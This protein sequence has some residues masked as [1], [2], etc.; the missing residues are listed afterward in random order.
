MD[1]GYISAHDFIKLSPDLSLV[2]LSP[3]LAILRGEVRKSAVH[4]LV[5]VTILQHAEQ[6]TNLA[7]IK[8]ALGEMYSQTEVIQALAF[9]LDRSYV[10]LSVKDVSNA[11]LWAALGVSAEQVDDRMR[12]VKLCVTG[13]D[14]SILKRKLAQKGL[15]VTSARKANLHVFVTGDATS[16]YWAGVNQKKLMLQ[17]SWCLLQLS[18]T[19]MLLGPVFSKSSGCWRCFAHN[20]LHNRPVDRFL[21]SNHIDWTIIPPLISD[22]LFEL[23]SLEIAKWVVLGE[24]SELSDHLIRLSVL[25]LSVSRHRARA[26]PQCMDCGCSEHLDPARKPTC[27]DFTEPEERYTTSGGVRHH[28]PTTTVREWK[29]LV[30]PMLGIVSSCVSA[31]STLNLKFCIATTD[32]GGLDTSYQGLRRALAFRAFGKGATE[33]EAQASA[34]GEAIERYSIVFQG[35]EI[36][37]NS[38]FSAFW[39]NEAIDPSSCLLMSDAQYVSSAGNLERFRPD[40]AREWSPL[41]SL[42][43]QDW[44]WLPTEYLYF[45]YPVTRSVCPAD[46]NGLA[47]GNTIS[48]AVVQGFLELIERDAF[49][50]WWANRIHPPIYVREEIY[51]LSLDE[52]L[53]VYTSMRRKI[54]FLDLTHDAAIPVVLAL[55]WCESECG[56]QQILFAAGAH[57]DAR[58]AALRAIGEINQ[59]LTA[60][61]SGWKP[62]AQLAHWLETARIQDYPQ[63]SSGTMARTPS[64]KIGE[65]HSLVQA[66]VDAARRINVNLLVLNATRPDIGVPVVKV[67]CPG[68]RH[69]WPRYAPGRLYDVPVQLGWRE[70]SLSENEL[71]PPPAMVL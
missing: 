16:E 4:G 25:H 5:P 11:A 47:A 30:D 24:K 26:R 21:R 52:Q 40:K 12:A 6:C 64:I 32:I 55:S 36:R 61:E 41:W 18:G 38:T 35:N 71:D 45:S 43:E 10:T 42:T 69:Y 33:D 23:A 51:T 44:R 34:L 67:V 49:A 31:P 46:S 66:C 53:K 14:H 15:L 54:E 39:T 68:L 63:L 1:R 9:L 19:E 59:K 56:G 37:R 58:I 70:W 50:I 48:E 20:H 3:S 65:N 29:K 13:D 22:A 17:S 27:P 57:F 28:H 7:Q 60:I 8:K 62:A 2:I